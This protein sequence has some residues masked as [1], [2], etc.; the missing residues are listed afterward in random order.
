MNQP[1]TE[2]LQRSRAGE[3]A[4]LEELMPAV[5][6]ELR[7]LARR[8]L[9]QGRDAQTLQPT[10]LV[11]E[12]YLRLIDQE[13]AGLEDRSHFLQLCAR[14][15]RN[16]LVDRARARNSTKRDGGERAD[17]D[18]AMEVHALGSNDAV[19]VIVF[20]ELLE[21]LAKL[22]ERKAKVVELR[23]FSGLTMEEVAAALHVSKRSVESDWSFA[24]AWLRRE[25]DSTELG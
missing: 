21:R 9:G 16:I 2:L 7:A 18:V 22:D 11:N 25:L 6:E 10:A 13:V 5:Y 1:F 20:D 14:V 12:V 23:Y 4:A 8:K 15:M 3:D 19:D 24:R 17:F